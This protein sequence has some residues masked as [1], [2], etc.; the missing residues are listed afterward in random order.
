MS[1]YY[2]LLDPDTSDVDLIRNSHGFP[3]S[4]S[5]FDSA[6]K[7]GEIYLANMDCKDYEIVG[8]CTDE[9]NHII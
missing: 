3:E 9:R 4:Y 6:K 1:H 8:L 5:S 7:D 2:V